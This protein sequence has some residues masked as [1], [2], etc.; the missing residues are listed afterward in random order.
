[1][2]ELLILGT[3][4]IFTIVVFVLLVM[5]ILELNI[6]NN[7]NKSSTY[8]PVWYKDTKMYYKWFKE[9][10]DTAL[11][12][13]IFKSYYRI[14]RK[15]KTTLIADLENNIDKKSIKLYALYILCDLLKNNLYTKVK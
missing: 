4:K 3:L 1:M 10:G 6:L 15:F 9:T 2:Y 14:S 7:I 5:F 8:I 11:Y 13:K 12:V